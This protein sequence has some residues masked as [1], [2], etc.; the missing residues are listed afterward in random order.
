MSFIITS[1]FWEK[2][3]IIFN[4]KFINFLLMY[5]TVICICKHNKSSMPINFFYYIK[6]YYTEKKNRQKKNEFLL[7][8]SSKSSDNILTYKIYFYECTNYVQD[9]IG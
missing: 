3:R 6:Q 9:P 2:Y 5:K 1:G 8:N 4:N 7:I